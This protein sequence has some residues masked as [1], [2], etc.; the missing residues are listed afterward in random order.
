VREIDGVVGTA[1][2]LNSNE[3]FGNSLDFAQALGGIWQSLQAKADHLAKHRT[4]AQTVWN[5]F[6]R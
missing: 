6:S 5:W 1:L 2:R 3:R 4:V